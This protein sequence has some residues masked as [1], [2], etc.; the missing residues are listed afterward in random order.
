MEDEREGQEESS[1]SK[2]IELRGCCEHCEW[3]AF[4]VFFIRVV[5]KWGGGGLVRNSMEWFLG[6]R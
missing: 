6:G 4:V 3:L 1:T 5:S 2:E